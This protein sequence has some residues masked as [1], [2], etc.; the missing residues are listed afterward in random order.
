M[1]VLTTGPIIAG[2]M[3]YPVAASAA[4]ETTGQP[5]T[6][7]VTYDAA[8]SL[9]QHAT[10]AVTVGD[11]LRERGVIAGDRDYVWPSQDV[12][13]SNDTTIV[14]RAA[15]P[16]A[17]VNGRA[18]NTII[19]SA[20]DV[21]ALLEEQGIRLGKYD[22]VTP[23]LADAVPANGIV[24]ISRIVTWE[25][26]EQHV[27]PMKTIHRLDFTLTP[28]MS[29]V[30]SRGAIG[31]REVMVRYTQRD[32]GA[33]QRTVVTT[34]I[35]SNGHPRIVADGVGEFEA[36]QRFAQR[37]L[38]K[39]AYIAASALNMVAT[40]YTAACAGCSGITAIGQRAGHGIVA[41]DPRIIPLGTRLF[42]PGYG[43]AVAGDTGGAIHG[44]RI[45]L[46]FNS[47]RDAMLFGRRQVMVYRL[48]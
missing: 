4:T 40:A 32:G 6:H 16:V 18:R 3:V 38:E 33:V 13:L 7:V 44:N 17:I 29:K 43:L 25:R 27:I 19:S 15:V 30:V 5:V 1:S 28:G 12:L 22:T 42:I 8:G 10:H 47:M 35:V 46:G 48:K 20:E 2:F 24:R 21:G 34:R 9:T 26:K 31:E 14:Y 39:T 45:D 11:F 36:F 23:S 37:G 41:V